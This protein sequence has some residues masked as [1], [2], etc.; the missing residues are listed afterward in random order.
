[1]EGVTT[2]R[3]LL[4]HPSLVVTRRPADRPKRKVVQFNILPHARDLRVHDASID[5][6]ERSVLERV[7]Y[8]QKENGWG[9]CPQ[10][11]PGVFAQRLAWFRAQVARLVGVVNPFTHEEFVGS[12]RARRRIAYSLAVESLKTKPLSQVDAHLDVF[13]KAEKI[14]F[15][16]K[17]DPCP[18]LIQ[19]RGKR[20]NVEVGCFLK[21]ME[22]RVYKAINHL[23]ATTFRGSG[24]PTVFK[25]LNMEQR[26]AALR[27]KWDRFV[28][29]V[30]IGADAKRFDQHVSKEALEY[31]HALYNRISGR[32][33]LRRLL[34]W[35]IENWCHGRV[36]DGSLKFKR[37]GGRASGD[38]N[39][40]L[41][42]VFI[43]CS[44]LYGLL[45]TLGVN[46]EI[47]DD[48]DD[49]LIICEERDSG[50]VLAALDQW[51]LDFGFEMT[52]EEP[53][54]RFERIDMCQTRPVF[55]NGRWIMV[56]NPAAGLSKDQCCL[57]NP[58]TP[59]ERGAWLGSV[60]VGGL[61]A[62]GG[63]PIYHHL[64]T[65]MVELS[66]GRSLDHPSL[67]SGFVLNSFGIDR[68][69]EVVTESNRVSFWEAFGVPPSTQIAMEMSVSREVR[70][71][72]RPPVL[73]WL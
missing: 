51:F 37:I 20:F 2:R 33:E 48:G 63:C 7:F 11:L 18:R 64:Y 62:V 29:P 59:V 4:S 25:G 5:N 56:R 66:E 9:P 49:F 60:G 44:I 28:K 40:A 42:N 12:Y 43:V 15:T 6:M 34:R 39:T 17:E 55:L 30:A 26:A 38:M 35:Q 24:A 1:M 22:H 52:V 45:E 71:G 46:A 19:P 73:P 53:V 70:V 13:V 36:K 68:S 41:G 67:E 31:E 69:N 21:P 50:L 61:A 65:T 16:K 58:G 23:F 54:G 57:T 8:V 72:A 32:W 14:D 10:P 47:A 3:S 27:T